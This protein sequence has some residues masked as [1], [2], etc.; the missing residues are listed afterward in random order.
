MDG[1]PGTEEAPRGEQAAQPPLRHFR[2]SLQPGMGSA[3]ELPGALVAFRTQKT[4]LGPSE[5]LPSLETPPDPSLLL[6]G[7]LDPQP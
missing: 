1:A 2:G 7:L 4:T 6:S 3:E 5:C